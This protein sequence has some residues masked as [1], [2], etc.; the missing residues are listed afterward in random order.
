[1]AR[2]VRET[3]RARESREPRAATASAGRTGGGQGGDGVGRADRGGQG[4][5]GV[6]ER[7][8]G[9]SDRERDSEHIVLKPRDVR[10]EWFAGLRSPPAA[11][12]PR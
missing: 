4:G 10:W 8:G 9:M 2:V 11:G 7:G 3:P 12:R 6:G 1:M 5:D